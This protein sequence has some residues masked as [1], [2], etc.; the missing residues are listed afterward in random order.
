MKSILI[1]DTTKEERIAIICEWILDD[2]GLADDGGIDL[3]RC[4]MHTSRE[5]KKSLR[6]TWNSMPD[7]MKK[8]IQNR[9]RDVAREA[10]GGRR[11][12]W[13]VYTLSGMDKLCGM[14]RIRYAERLILR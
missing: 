11:G 4:M 3:W 9:L 2:D 10:A 5:R 12:V 6:S 7:F 13:D 1:K 8:W 14:W